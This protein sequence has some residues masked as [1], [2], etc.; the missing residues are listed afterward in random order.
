VEE[1]DPFTQ[2]E[3]KKIGESRNH[4]VLLGTKMKARI[5]WSDFCALISTRITPTLLALVH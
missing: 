2:E 4:F 5:S 1:E 3:G